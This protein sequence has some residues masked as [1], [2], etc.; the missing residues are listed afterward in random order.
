MVRPAVWLLLLAAL[1]CTA[2]VIALNSGTVAVGWGELAHIFLGGGAELPRQMVLELRLP[3]ALAAFAVGGLLALSGALLQV[4]LRNPLA[5]P[6]ILGV[7]GG[8]AVAALLAM[9][10]GI[11]GWWF[12]ASAFGGALVTVLLVFGLARGAG[13]W[14]DTRL[15]LTGVMV[16]SGWG[17]LISF[18]LAV[19]PGRELRG[20][21]FWLMGDLSHVREPFVALLVLGTGLAF[22]LPWARTLNVLSRGELQAAALGVEV[23]RAR[24]AIYLAASLFTATAVTLAGSVGFVGLVVPHLMRLLLGS[25]HRLLLPAVVLAGGTLLLCADTLARSV[26]APRQLPVGVLTA[27]LGVPLF[28]Y[29]L[30]RSR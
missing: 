25:D 14:S 22:I 17:A 29:L 5:D 8:A 15:L 26:I 28:L 21:L 16:A 30:R 4:L 13:S 9:L 2:F 18:L 6:Y 27:M 10:A 23:S 24:L 3:R 1:A 11:S 20:M 12:S 7:S 19:A